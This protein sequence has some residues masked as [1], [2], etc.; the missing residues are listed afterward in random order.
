MFIIKKHAASPRK[1]GRKIVGQLLRGGR[2]RSGAPFPA[3]VFYHVA[4]RRS[5]KLRL[6][7]RK[8]HAVVT[9]RRTTSGQTTELHR[10]LKGDM[11]D[12]GLVK[13]AG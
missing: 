8:N 10:T 7:I 13:E 5:Q 2:P 3:P 9:T 6:L 1:M 12:G 4:T 11:I